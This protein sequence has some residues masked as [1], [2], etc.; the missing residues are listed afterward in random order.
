MVPSTVT[1]FEGVSQHVRSLWTSDVAGTVVAGKHGG[2]GFDE[3]SD[4]RRSGP[5]VDDRCGIDERSESGEADLS[6]RRIRQS[7]I[8]SAEDRDGNVADDCHDRV[9]GLRLSQSTDEA[10]SDG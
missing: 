1:I 7:D 2:A 4:V 8:S 3:Y 5:A 6:V 9:L 10:Q